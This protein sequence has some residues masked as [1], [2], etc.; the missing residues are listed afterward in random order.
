MSDKILKKN[1]HGLYKYFCEYEYDAGIVLNGEDVRDIKEMN[2]EIRDSFVTEK[3]GELFLDNILL[4]S[5]PTKRQRKKL[6]LKRREID[7]IVQILRNKRYHGFVQSLKL[8]KNNL[9]KVEIGIGK[10]KK[11][12]DHKSS[13]KRSS[14]KRQVEKE[15][16]E[17]Y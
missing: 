1:K 11:K 12:I 3:D 10:T 2:F 9:V 15:I 6:L 4:K 7:K 13:E 17:M 16:K 14:E 8:S 5:N